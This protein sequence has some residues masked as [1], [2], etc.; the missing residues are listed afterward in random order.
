M[1]RSTGTWKDT[2]DPCGARSRRHHP[3]L[4]FR[5]AGN[6]ERPPCNRG[7]AQAADATSPQS[8]RGRSV[9]DY[10][11]PL[12]AFDMHCPIMSM[13][14]AVR[15]TVASNECPTC[16]P[17]EFAGRGGAKAHCGGRGQRSESRADMG[18]RKLADSRFGPMRRRSL[19]PER[20]ARL[21]EVEGVHFFSL[22]KDGPRAPEEFPLHFMGTEDGF[23]QTA[24]LISCL[25][26]VVSVDTSI[27]HLSGALGKPT[28]LLNRFNPDWRWLIGRRDSPWYPTMRLYEQR[29]PGDWDLS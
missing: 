20:L 17:D 16:M 2:S 13:P 10:A 25:D 11:E 5:H 27:A 29:L 15:T 23:A 4:S 19:P 12:P 7:S 28:W 9:V 24:A 21:F 8:T 3:V 18:W 22:Q 1:E 14:L 6:S 26:L